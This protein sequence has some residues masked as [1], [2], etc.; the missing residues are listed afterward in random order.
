MMSN[1][2]IVTEHIRP[3]WASVLT[4]LQPVVPRQPPLETVLVTEGRLLTLYSV[5]LKRLPSCNDIREEGMLLMNLV[6]WIT[7]IKPM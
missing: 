6:D 7:N 4:I 1:D 5:I 3:T 2:F